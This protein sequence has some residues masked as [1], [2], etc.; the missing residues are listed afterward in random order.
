MIAYI[1]SF[2]LIFSAYALPMNLEKA[3]D[4]N[5]KFEKVEKNED[6]EK[7][8]SRFF[9]REPVTFKKLNPGEDLAES[10]KGSV[11]YFAYA[12]DGTPLAVVKKLP[13]DDYIDREELSDEVSSLYERYFYGANFHVPKLIGTAEFATED[14]ASAYIIESIAQGKSINN[15]VKDTAAKS[16][17]ARF[18]AYKNLKKSIEST[19]KSFAEMHQLQSSTSY[20]SYYDD[21]FQASKEGTFAGPYG[22][23]HGDA[24]LGN[25][26]FDTKSGKTTF[27]D[28]SF[29]PRSIE[30]GAPVGLD[31]GKFL[32]TLEA[33]GAFYGLST[34][35]IEELSSTFSTTY[36]AHNQ[37]MDPSLMDKYV[38]VAFKDFAFPDDSFGDDS[39]SQGDFLYRYAVAKVGKERK[40]TFA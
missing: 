30:Q 10:G 7:L 3:G 21:Y 33:I 16:G 20:A 1:L 34:G 24:H 23:I 19:A 11:I 27:I 26:F 4:Y 35:E 22:I 38:E 9:G 31:C 5:K 28:L 6:L 18:F 2:F 14:D 32:F 25:I 36:L 12:N 39:T 15:L 37:K 40:T 8:N 13:V 17:N 29:M